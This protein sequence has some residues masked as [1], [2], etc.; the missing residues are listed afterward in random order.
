MGV[1]D[2]ISRPSL[3]TKIS[4]VNKDVDRTNQFNDKSNVFTLHTL[5]LLFYRI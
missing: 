1:S 4:D 3:E 2:E 5:P